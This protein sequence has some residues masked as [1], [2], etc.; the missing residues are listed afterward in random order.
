VEGIAYRYRTGIAWRDLP[1]VFGQR[2]TNITRQ[3]GGGVE[4]HELTTDLLAEPA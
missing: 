1:V 2:Q 4:P 3:I